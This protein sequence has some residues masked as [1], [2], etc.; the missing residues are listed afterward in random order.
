[1]DCLE[2]VVIKDFH[3]KGIT[4]RKKN[5]QKKRIC[6]KQ[7]TLIIICHKKVLQK[8]IRKISFQH[9]WLNIFLKSLSEKS[10]TF[11]QLLNTYF[12]AFRDLLVY[13]SREN[14]KSRIEF[15][16]SPD[17]KNKHIWTSPDFKNEE[18]WTSPDLPK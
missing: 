6:R 10:N 8:N 17:F 15:L 18:F 4:G 5:R 11:Q 14:V 16:T 12:R 3:Q 13:I 9:F 7:K 2:T 1:M